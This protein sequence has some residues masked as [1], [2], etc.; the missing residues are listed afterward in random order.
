M[1]DWRLACKIQIESLSARH[2]RL[3]KEDKK[4]LIVCRITHGWCFT[5]QSIED[6]CKE[7]EEIKQTLEEML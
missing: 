5:G 1:R 7:V 2:K 3:S 4:D 6:H